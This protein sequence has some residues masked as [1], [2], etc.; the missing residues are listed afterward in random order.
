[1]LDRR[2]DILQIAHAN[3]IAAVSY[4][5][6]VRMLIEKM[7]YLGILAGEIYPSEVAVCAITYQPC[8]LNR[9][10]CRW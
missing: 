9:H 10:Q 3:L 5:Y 6:G 4:A 7:V 2:D 1:M 8:P